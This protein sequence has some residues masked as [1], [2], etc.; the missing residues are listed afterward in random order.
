ML[1]AKRKYVMFLLS[2]Y[3]DSDENAGI[4]DNHPGISDNEYASPNE[5][6]ISGET[7]GY[8]SRLENENPY[9]SIEQPFESFR[10][11]S[12]V[13][14]PENNVAKLKVAD[15]YSKVL[16]KSMRD[17][18]TTNQTRTTFGEY[19]TVLPKSERHQNG[20]VHNG[21]LIDLNKNAPCDLSSINANDER[22]VNPL[23]NR[24]TDQPKTT[25]SEYST[26]VPRSKRDQQIHLSN[27]Y[28]KVLPR[29][30][31]GKPNTLNN[32]YSTVLPRSVRVNT[33][34][35]N[36]EYANP[37]PGRQRFLDIHGIDHVQANFNEYDLPRSTSK[38]RKVSI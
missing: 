20:N 36:H 11:T 19:A 4:I 22:K 14:F 29:S 23:N 30:E 37:V 35:L 5:A 18:A 2:E 31:R 3:G 21:N 8:E 10:N 6:V 15:E 27:E 38:R 7:F 9:N 25:L 32:E 24:I 33:L 34:Q 28:S 12:Y 13:D 26:V 17:N 16:P 1:G